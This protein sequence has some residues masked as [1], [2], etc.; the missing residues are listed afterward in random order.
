MENVTLQWLLETFG[1]GGVVLVALWFLWQRDTQRAQNSQERLTELEKG[2]QYS[3]KQALERSEEL[4]TQ[5][6][7]L[8]TNVVSKNTE[9][10][11][12]VEQV[13]IRLQSTISE[14]AAMLGN[15]S[16][17][18]A[19]SRTEMARTTAD[20]QAILSDCQVTL[21]HMEVETRD[22]FS[23]ISKRLE[24]LDWYIVGQLTE[25]PRG[26]KPLEGTESFKA[27]NQDKDSRR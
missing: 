16:A 25:Q 8:L 1:P 14:F 18:S 21:R 22:N 2:Q 19:E 15:F 24:R 7:D 23:E 17:Q 26:T 13:L 11:K 5:L 10:S 4:Q 27:A 9:S 6:F 12:A 3:Y 20:L